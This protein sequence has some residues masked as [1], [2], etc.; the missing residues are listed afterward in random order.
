MSDD[1]PTQ[2]FPE[3]GDNATERITTGEVQEDLQEEKKKSRGL[4]IGLIVAGVLLLV[5]IIVLVFFLGRATGTP[6]AIGTESPA[7]IPSDSATAGPSES[8]TPSATPEETEEPE[9][10]EQPEQPP[11]QPA[12]TV[13]V[14]SFSV[15]TSTVFC[16]K[17][18]QPSD[19]DLFFKWSTSHGERVYFG[20]NTSDASTAPFFD[21]LPLDG[22]TA[23]NFPSGYSPFQYACG[24]QSL[25]YT[26]TVVDGD[27]H[28]AS[29]S[30]TITDVNFNN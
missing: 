15:D 29:K 4:L 20:I 24:N 13:K 16:G 3:Q 11:Q 30:V 26:I 8:P 19:I 1:T 28:K 9:E 17:N 10:P 14:D 21:N 2:R 25:K 7:P 22:D 12:Q 5:A 6:G 18:G 23:S 27:N